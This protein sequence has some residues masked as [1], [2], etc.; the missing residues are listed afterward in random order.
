[1][2]HLE[3]LEADVDAAA[4]IRGRLRVPRLGGRR[5]FAST[6]RGTR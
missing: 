5:S 1:V 4:E 3:T 2:S 6:A